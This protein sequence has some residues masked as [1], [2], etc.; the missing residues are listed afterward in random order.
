MRLEIDRRQ[1]SQVFCRS[2]NVVW[3]R[4]IT[5]GERRDT[6][7]GVA[8]RDLQQAQPTNH[9]EKTG[10]TT[11]TSLASSVVKRIFDV[12]LWKPFLAPCHRH[13][14]QHHRQQDIHTFV[15]RPRT[16]RYT[17][18]YPPYY[19]VTVLPTTLNWICLEHFALLDAVIITA[20]GQ[21]DLYCLPY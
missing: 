11:F 6:D 14:P 20:L 2:K 12:S 19:C 15:Y 3:E 1:H 5:Y 16:C 7:V 10:N 13:E 21:G 4:V 17:H 8:R 9:F 18:Q